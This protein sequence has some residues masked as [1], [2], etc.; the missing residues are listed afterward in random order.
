MYEE[1]IILIY[2]L[3]LLPL[4]L[5]SFFRPATDGP[6]KY[7]SVI[8]LLNILGLTWNIQCPNVAIG[9]YGSSKYL[10][11]SSVSFSWTTAKFQPNMSVK[12]SQNGAI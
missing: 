10:V 3:Q 7:D 5:N 9:L 4:E 12:V 1:Q 11:S 2:H 8:N 6:R